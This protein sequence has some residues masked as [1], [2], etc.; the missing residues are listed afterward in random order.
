MISRSN[1]CNKADKKMFEAKSF[2]KIYFLL[3]GNE[4][5]PVPTGTDLQ[6]DRKTN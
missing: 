3:T 1:N 2:I 4:W 6:I 5:W